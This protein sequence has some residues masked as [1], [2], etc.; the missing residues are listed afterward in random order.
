MSEEN[1]A[2][3]ITD[4]GSTTKNKTGSWR[5]FKPVVDINKCTGCNLCDMHCPDSAIKVGKDKKAHVNYDYCK[6]CGICA[7]ICPVKAIAMERDEK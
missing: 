4:V 5:T 1:I 3:I 2:A 6:G 7:E